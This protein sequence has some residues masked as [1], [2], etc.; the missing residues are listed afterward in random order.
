MRGSWRRVALLVVAAP[1]VLA[2]SCKAP[3]TEKSLVGTWINGPEVFEFRSDKTYT[4]C[5]GD[6]IYT[7]AMGAQPI[8]DEGTFE[9][10]DESLRLVRTRTT[11]GRYDPNGSEEYQK[12]SLAEPAAQT[13][14][15]V[16]LSKQELKI[17][18]MRSEPPTTFRRF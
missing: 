16:A 4:L 8:Y 14:L 2:S 3:L 1:A 17:W 18:Y 11:C 10:K 13:L 7:G 6:E 12:R 9:F 15:R 5:T